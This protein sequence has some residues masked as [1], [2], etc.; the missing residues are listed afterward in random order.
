MADLAYKLFLAVLVCGGITAAARPGGLLSFLRERLDDLT[1][2]GLFPSMLAKPLL[3]CTP[4]MGSI[5]GTLVYWTATWAN[6]Q[7]LNWVLVYHWPIVVCGTAL[8]NHLLWTLI[9]LLETLYDNA[10]TR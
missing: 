9:A 4:C 3:L 1:E 6:H 5:W 2:R 10:N 7:A 8:V